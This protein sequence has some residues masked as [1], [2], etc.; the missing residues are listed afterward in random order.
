MKK[1]FLRYIII[2]GSL[3]LVSW[4]DKGHRVIAK[5]AE[6]HLTP[7][8]KQAVQK[9]LGSETLAEVSNYAD[10][11]RANRNFRF[12]GPWHYVNVPGGYNFEQFSNAVLTMKEDNVYKV[13]LV[14]E[15][16]LKDPSISK[17]KQ[18]FALK[19][20][21]H[22]VGDLHQP[23]HVSH[24]EDKG[25]NNIL[26]KFNGFDDNLH[27]LWDNGLIEHEGTAYKKMAVDYDSATPTEIK[28]WQSDSLMVWLWESYQISTILYD[29]AAKNPAFDEGYYQTHL[30]VLHK[31]IEKAGIRLAGMLNSIFDAP[32]GP[33]M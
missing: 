7:K 4:G 18:A 33:A 26:I 9:I 10:E 27:G 28:K 17:T 6:N 30:P 3:I 25:G 23:M 32:D 16:D 14:C 8:T 29:E 21:V 13:I 2:I 19:L 15:K 1:Y 5:I 20:L 22:L 11:I 24:A 12:M 31:R